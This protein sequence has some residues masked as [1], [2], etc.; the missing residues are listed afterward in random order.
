MFRHS[1]R[2][3]LFSRSGM[4]LVELLAASTITVL[5]VGTLGSLSL[6][7]HNTNQYQFSQGQS[8]Q[9]GQVVI[10]R[11]Q[12]Q[13][14][15][16][17]ANQLFP[18][19]AVFSETVAS[20]SFPNTLVV[21]RPVG[22]PANPTGMPL[23]NELVVYCPNPN[24]DNELWEITK[25]LDTRTAPNLS[26]L[27][28]WQ[29]ELADFRTNISADRI[30]LTD[31]LRVGTLRDAGGNK[32]AKRAVLRFDA[33]QRPSAAQWQDFLANRTTWGELPWVQ[34]IHGRVTG[35]A[36]S[37]CRIEFHLR[38]GDSQDD[39]RDVAIPFFGSAA[40]YFDLDHP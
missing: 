31:L 26:N 19:F 2:S 39:R 22:A 24:A 36:Q 20:N 17:T 30:V 18:G 27:T 5:M 7:V 11:L 34:G 33:V 40:A 13:I 37:R 25:P 10:L 23:I 1:D 32:I 8:L 38:P 9:H 4:T 12:R 15:Q 6:A 3:R 14:Q 16:S 29:Q 21:W 28:A 35:L